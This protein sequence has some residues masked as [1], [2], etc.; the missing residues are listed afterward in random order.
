M[1]TIFSIIIAFAGLIF[2]F[3]ITPVVFRWVGLSIDKILDLTYALRFLYRIFYPIAILAVLV[4][5]IRFKDINYTEPL[6]TIYF[7]FL[8][9]AIITNNLFHWKYKRTPQKRRNVFTN[10]SRLDIQEDKAIIGLLIYILFTPIVGLIEIIF[11]V[12]KYFL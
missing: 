3:F 8:T 9:L 11:L 5:K 10:P 6:T 4:P 7:S 12:K 2:I 1:N